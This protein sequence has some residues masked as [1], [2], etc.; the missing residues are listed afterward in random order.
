MRVIMDATFTGEDGML[1]VWNP[2]PGVAQITD[3]G[4]LLDGTTVAW[5]DDNDTVREM[6]DGGYLVLMEGSP[7]KSA[8][9]NLKPKSK[10]SERQEQSAET[11]PM[12]TEVSDHLLAA[13]TGDD[14][15]GGGFTLDQSTML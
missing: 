14:T 4:H 10:E 7:V 8:K 9:K 3:E 1:K 15:D 5:V 12:S 6:I 13:P 2:G 11:S